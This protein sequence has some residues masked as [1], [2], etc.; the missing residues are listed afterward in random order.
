MEKQLFALLRLGLRN[1]SAEIENLS[2][3]NVFSAEQWSRI[4][5]FAQ[6]QG[7]L[8]VMLDGIDRLDATGYGATKE[9][10]K[11]QKLEW[12][13]NVLNGYEVRNQHQLEVISDL[14]NRWAEAGI[15]M[16]VMKGQAMGD[17]FS[18]SKTSS[19]R[20]Y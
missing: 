15:R 20:R 5:D 19:S 7:V 14:Q 2:V 12:I 4:G 8:G 18:Q 9:L 6:E 3:F 16:M 11:D 13:G 17:I 1:S 10:S